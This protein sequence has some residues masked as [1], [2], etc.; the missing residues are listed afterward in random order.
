MSDPI[1]VER[2]TLDRIDLVH[3]QT[4]SELALKQAQVEVERDVMCRDLVV[5][6]LLR[7]L[8]RK[9]TIEMS[10]P[11][12]WW[13]H[14]KQ[15]LRRRWPRLFGWLT[16]RVVTKRVDVGAIVAELEAAFPSKTIVPY[17]VPLMRWRRN[18]GRKEQDA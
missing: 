9:E 4:I 18:E 16:A 11:E 2:I 8:G 14:L 3:E 10:C 5:R 1:Q 12:T 13:Q 6:G 17:S 7:G 15:A